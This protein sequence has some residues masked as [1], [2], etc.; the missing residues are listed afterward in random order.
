MRDE[1]LR[2]VMKEERSRGRR[3]PQRAA[4]LQDRRKI[5]RL[6]EMLANQECSE[7]DF[8]QAIRDLGLKDES[9]QFFQLLKLWREYRGTS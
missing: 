5:H 9:P 3:Q 8:L 1:D 6:S 7:R 2:D 4:I